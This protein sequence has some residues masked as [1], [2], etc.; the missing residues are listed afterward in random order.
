MRCGGIVV[1]GGHSL[2]M[3]QPKAWLPFG[4]ELL[5]PR[6]V[7]RLAAVVTP[8][9]VVAAEAQTLPPLPPEIRLGRDTIANCGPLAG[10][11]TGMA[12]L[13]AEVESVFVCGCD[14][15][16]MEPDFIREIIR[17]L[18][19]SP[20]MEIAVPVDG[21]REYPLAAAYRT[22]ILSRL[23]QQLASRQLRLRDLF[24]HLPTLRIPVEELR[25]CDA[26]LRSLI[27]L[28]SPTDYEQAL[29]WS[30]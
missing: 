11:A 9:V 28:N 10:I 22:R 29:K 24:Q 14:C 17:Q 20:S 1:C 18:A 15:P 16:G 5:L 30:G 21:E 26:E 3:G 25:S 4:D 12:L 6:V 2:R 23:T 19:A 13:A 8:I 7:R 27:N